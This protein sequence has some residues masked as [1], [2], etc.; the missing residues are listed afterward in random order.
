M[1][2]LLLTAGSGVSADY[3][4]KVTTQRLSSSMRQQHCKERRAFLR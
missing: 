3:S 4:E 1:K 2:N